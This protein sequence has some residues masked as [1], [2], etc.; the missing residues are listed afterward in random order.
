MN[1]RPNR[2][3]SI[4]AAPCGG[5]RHSD[6]WPWSPQAG[7]GGSFSSGVGVHGR[8]AGRVCFGPRRGGEP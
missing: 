5:W 3:P 1:H 7:N 2:P 6:C 4:T 8:R